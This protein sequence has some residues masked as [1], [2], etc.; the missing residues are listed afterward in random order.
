[1]I[2]A[3]HLAQT[4]VSVVVAVALFR[5]VDALYIIIDIMKERRK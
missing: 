4:V 2:I 3:T 5:I 1:M